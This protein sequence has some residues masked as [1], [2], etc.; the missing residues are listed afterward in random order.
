MVI[1]SEGNLKDHIQQAETKT[2]NIS[3]EIKASSWIRR[4]ESENKII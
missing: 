2:N 4:N 1:N 3:R